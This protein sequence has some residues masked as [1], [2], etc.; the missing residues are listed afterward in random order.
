[1]SKRLKIFIFFCLM[2]LFLIVGRMVFLASSSGEKWRSEAVTVSVKEGLLSAI[3]GRIFAANGDLLV[4]SERRYDLYWLEPAADEKRQQKILRILEKNFAFSA[5]GLNSSTVYPIAV[6]YDLTANELEKADGLSNIYPELA[7]EL[8]WER[9]NSD[10]AF[11]PGIVRQINNMEYGFSGVEK[12]FDAILRGTP[13][14]YTV[15]LDRHGR[16]MN[17]TFR[18]VTP[19]QSGK[20]V[21]LSEESAA[22]K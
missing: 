9:R 11:D 15:M 8:R 17:S 1:M 19:P 3:R 10:N 5:A 20:D 4:W 22:G 21:Y 12:T 16:W 6:K 7:I 2:V 14:K 18:I 13:G